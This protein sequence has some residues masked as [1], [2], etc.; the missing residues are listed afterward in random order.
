[1]SENV[2]PVDV[3]LAGTTWADRS[4]KEVIPTRPSRPKVTDAVK[5]T[6]AIITQKAR[7][8][9]LAL[10][11]DLVRLNRDRDEMIVE[12][13]KRHDKKPEGLRAIL[14]H[15]STFKTHRQPN[16]QNA[17]IHAKGLEVNEG[18]PN[19][20]LSCEFLLKACV[21]SRS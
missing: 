13:A 7:E 6:K 14:S 1:M 3:P 18:K 16:L 4:N 9:N 17:L 8:K 5:A 20:F 2:P 21:L 12:L 19:V 11:D 10:A 15:G